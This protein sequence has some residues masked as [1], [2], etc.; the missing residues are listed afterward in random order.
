MFK[1]DQDI[2]PDK[3]LEERL[4]LLV[5]MLTATIVSIGFLFAYPAYLRP[6]ILAVFIFIILSIYIAIT[7]LQSGE[8]AILYGG[9]ANEILKNRKICYT[10]VNADGK[11]VLQNELAKNFLQGLPVLDFLEMHL[12][13]DENNR[14]KLKQLRTSAEHLKEDRLEVTLKFDTSTVFS[15]QEWYRVSLRPISLN[16]DGG[17]EW[18]VLRDSTS[19]TTFISCGASKTSLRKKPWTP[20]FRKNGA[21]FY[22]FLN[23]MPIG[24]YVLNA[25]GKVEYV[26]K[27]LSRMLNTSK[28][29]ILG[30]GITDFLPQ[31]AEGEQRLNNACSQYTAYVRSTDGGISEYLVKVDRFKQGSEVQ[32]RGAVIGGIPTDASLKQAYEEAVSETNSIFNLSPFGMMLLDTELVIKRINQRFMD[33]LGIPSSSQPLDNYLSNYLD[34]DS[35][36]KIKK[37]VGRICF[38]NR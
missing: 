25:K 12:V 31:S 32:T 38:R 19:N 33:I 16:A 9:L 10:I 4:L 15:G 5:F 27:T 35:I 26:N 24:L 1:N 3:I 34:E 13:N 11:T 18:T 23:F 14:Q 37:T 7:I 30:K 22:N 17:E 2:R 36:G 6:V 21:L 28:E 20:F 29:N 8:T